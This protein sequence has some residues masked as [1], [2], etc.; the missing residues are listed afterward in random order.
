MPMR[1]EIVTAER[2]LFQGDVDAVVAPGI[3]G[4]IGILPKHA[5]LMTVLQPGELRYRTGDGEES[6]AVTGGFIDVHGD[7]VSRSRGRGGAGGRDRPCK[8]RGSRLSRSTAHRRASGRRRP[9]TGTAF[10][11]QG[12]GTAKRDAPP[13]R[14]RSAAA[15]ARLPGL[16]QSATLRLQLP[17]RPRAGSGST[18]STAVRRRGL[19]SVSAPRS[20]RL[21]TSARS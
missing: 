5:A 10:A 1:L 17:L 18:S 20:G 9:R 8:G 19:R 21:Q 3:D 6:F 2:V 16:R 14:R 7:K 11:A 15:G 12:A 13:A 4:E